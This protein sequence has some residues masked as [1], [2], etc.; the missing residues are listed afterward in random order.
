[1]ALPS[2]G[3][4]AAFLQP[5]TISEMDWAGSPYVDESTIS[6]SY[7]IGTSSG[8]QLG[9]IS[10]TIPHKYRCEIPPTD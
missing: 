7:V 5:R 2:T 3:D 4:I 9:L 6:A 10:Y 8:I 1:M